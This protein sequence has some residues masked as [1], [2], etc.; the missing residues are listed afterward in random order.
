[1]YVDD[2]LGSIECNLAW[3]C[4]CTFVINYELS[5]YRYTIKQIC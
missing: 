3:K 1:M 4:I 5:E 2:W